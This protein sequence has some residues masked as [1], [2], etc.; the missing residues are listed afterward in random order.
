MEYA[1][2]GWPPDG[3]TLDLDHRSFSYAGKFVMSTTGKAVARSDD[4]IVGAVAFNEDRTDETTLWFRYVTVREDRRGEGIGPELL[5][6]ALDRAA[7][8]GYEQVTIGV[9]NPFAYQAAYRAGFGFTGDTTG[10]AEL[11]LAWP[12]DRSRQTYQAGLD[13]YRERELSP[14]ESSFLDRH[15][16]EEPPETV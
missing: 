13:Q 2:L 3:P 4:D 5:S 7:E 12:A 16:N 10:I 15:R 8:R 14:A 1:V 6:F 11:V 9:N